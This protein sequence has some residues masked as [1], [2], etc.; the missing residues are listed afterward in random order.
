MTDIGSTVLQA[1]ALVAQAASV[2]MKIQEAEK[3][4]AEEIAR[5]ET[6]K[7]ARETIATSEIGR[8]KETGIAAL[9]ERGAQAAYET[10]GAMRKAEQTASS[11]EAR[12]G[13]GGVRAS[14]TALAAAQQETDIAYAGAQRI[15]EAGA[16]QMKIGGLQLKNQLVGGREQKSLLTMEYGQRITEQKRKLTE[17][18][19]NATEMINWTLLGGLAGVYGS[20]YNSSANPANWDWS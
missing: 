16:A 12:I 17:L 3:D 15:A 14:G 7:T 5:L 2:S 13:A 11:A 20:F 9:S 19:E 6:Q 1:A 10:A 4:Y 8:A 18:E